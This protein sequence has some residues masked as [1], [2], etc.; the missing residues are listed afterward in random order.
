MS[1][2]WKNEARKDYYGRTYKCLKDKRIVDEMCGVVKTPN[3]Y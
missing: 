2:L 1:H 3:D